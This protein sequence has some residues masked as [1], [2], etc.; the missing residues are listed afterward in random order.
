MLNNSLSGMDHASVLE[1]IPIRINNSH[2]A[3]AFLFDLSQHGKFNCDFDRLSLS[4]DRWG[5]HLFNLVANMYL[6][7]IF[8]ELYNNI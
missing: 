8:H 6:Y 4:N 1:E 2:L 3:Q 5:L 7:V